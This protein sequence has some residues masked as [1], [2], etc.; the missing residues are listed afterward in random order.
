MA[1]NLGGRL[2]AAEQA[3]TIAEAARVDAVAGHMR[4]L[5]GQRETLPVMVT[6]TRENTGLGACNAYQSKEGEGG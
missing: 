3:A 6:H 4:E 2:G 1:V 5:E